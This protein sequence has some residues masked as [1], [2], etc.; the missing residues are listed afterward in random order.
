VLLIIPCFATTKQPSKTKTKPKNQTTIMDA[1]ALLPQDVAETKINALLYT[2]DGVFKDPIRFVINSPTYLPAVNVNPASPLDGDVVMKPMQFMSGKNGEKTR[3]NLT[4]RQFPKEPF[5]LPP[6]SGYQLG[7]GPTGNYEAVKTHFEFPATELSKASYTAMFGADCADQALEIPGRV[8]FSKYMAVMQEVDQ[9]WRMWCAALIMAD[10]SIRSVCRDEYLD[11]LGGEE[12]RTQAKLLQ[13]STALVR[14][15]KPKKEEKEGHPYVL[16]QKAVFFDEATFG[17]DK[18]GAKRRGNAPVKKAKAVKKAVDDSPSSG[19]VEVPS[20]PA[21]NEPLP[22]GV[23]GRRPLPVDRMQIQDGKYVEVP[24]TAQE[25]Q[26]LVQ[27]GDLF[28]PKVKLHLAT[29]VQ[30]QGHPVRKPFTLV[31][32]LYRLTWLGPGLGSRRSANRAGRV[33]M[34]VDPAE[35]ADIQQMATAPPSKVQAAPPSPSPSKVVGAVE[36][37]SSPVVE[38]CDSPISPME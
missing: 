11:L 32:E 38:E 17:D 26:D 13:N 6:M 31:M 24:M 28:L 16:T 12:K 23:H 35:L 33:E 10:R 8:G 4:H 30:P 36:Y 7:L 22:A 21:V 15:S 37:P 29:D 2:S 25:I 1:S 20:E 27:D 14:V 18:A 5:L 34:A 19:Q 9:T 3:Y